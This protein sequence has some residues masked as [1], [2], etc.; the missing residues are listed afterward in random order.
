MPARD[1]SPCPRWSLRAAPAGRHGLLSVRWGMWYLLLRSRSRRRRRIDPVVWRRWLGPLGVLAM[2]PTRLAALGIDHLSP[3]LVMR[4]DS[5]LG[6]FRRN[7][8]DARR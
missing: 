1:P 4:D 8:H 6:A 2:D 7:R 5:Q 3:A